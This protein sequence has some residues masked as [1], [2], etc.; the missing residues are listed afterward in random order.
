MDL[1][2]TYGITLEEDGITL[3]E[4]DAMLV[5]QAGRCAICGRGDQKLVVDHNHVTGAVCSLLCHLCNA[6]IGCACE[7]AGILLQG[8]AY[9]RSCVNEGLSAE[10]VAA[11]A[12][13]GASRQP[14][15]LLWPR[16]DVAGGWAGRVLNDFEADALAG[17]HGAVALARDGGEVVKDVG[18]V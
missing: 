12:V 8:A 10:R 5:R 6:M 16:L 17:A 14:G 9:L 13:A 1:K 2:A 15:T 18:A 4:D 7:D 11:L 3:E